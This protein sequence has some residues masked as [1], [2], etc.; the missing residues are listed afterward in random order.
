MGRD[1]SFEGEFGLGSHTVSLTVTDDKGTRAGDT[2]LITILPLGGPDSVTILGAEFTHKTK[3]LLVE[4]TSTRQPDAVLTLESHGP[5]T[6]SSS[7]GTYVFDAKAG[8]LRNGANVTV[9]SSYGGAATAPIV[10]K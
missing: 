2:V 6:F 10:V 3:Q 7:N 1:I 5:M 4:A 9:I 8:N